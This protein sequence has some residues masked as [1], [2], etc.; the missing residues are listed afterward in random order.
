MAFILHNKKYNYDL[1]LGTG[2]TGS[3]HL[4]HDD[5]NVQY[6][7][8]VSTDYPQD[9]I[10]DMTADDPNYQGP[11]TTFEEV[12][13]EA[14]VLNYI[15]NKLY[16]RFHPNL[17]YYV[18]SGPLTNDQVP[19]E[20]RNRHGEDVIMI[21][22]S[23]VSGLTINQIVDNYETGGQDII[24]MFKLMTDL[25]SALYTLETINVKYDDLNGNNVIYDAKSNNFVIIDFGD[26]TVNDISSSNHNQKVDFFPNSSDFSDI[27]HVLVNA[28]QDYIDSRYETF[29]LFSEN[30]NIISLTI[31]TFSE[32]FPER[33]VIINGSDSV[34]TYRNGEIISTTD[35]NLLTPNLVYE[36][37]ILA[38]RNKFNKL[39]ITLNLNTNYRNYDILNRTLSYYQGHDDTLKLLAKEILSRYGIVSKN[40]VSPPYLQSLSDRELVAKLP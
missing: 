7:V 27:L 2:I 32:T 4:I 39:G 40:Y 33:D 24:D 12:E 28:Y 26:A 11:Y 5:N 38:I 8:K 31:K 6:A 9:M 25:L 10:E 21:I 15:H 18:D 1:T 3:V 29:R 30:K 36:T 16:G 35:T 22:E 19:V 17:V 14:K 13:K 23:Y 34:I 37:N 20:M